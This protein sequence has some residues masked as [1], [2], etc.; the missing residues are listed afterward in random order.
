MSGISWS[1]RRAPSLPPRAAASGAMA[2]PTQAWEAQRADEGRVPRGAGAREAHAIELAQACRRAL[3]RVALAAGD[4]PK[5]PGL[6]VNGVVHVIGMIGA[7]RRR[8]R[9]HD[10]GL[11]YLAEGKAGARF[12]RSALT[13]SRTSACV[14]ESI[15]SA[16]DWSKIGPAWRSQLLSAR[17]VQRIES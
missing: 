15:S 17:L 11:R 10:V 8:V 2:E 3:D 13:P 9:G 12:S 5:G 4:E 6:S 7:R 1:W 16:S 14:K